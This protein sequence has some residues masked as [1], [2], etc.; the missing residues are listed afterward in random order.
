MTIGTRR[1]DEAWGTSL[2]AAIVPWL[3]TR[4]LVVGAFGAARH[5]VDELAVVPRPLQIGQGLL[6][7]DAAFYADIAGGG[8]DAVPSAGLRFFPMVPYLGRI[9]GLLPGL[10][11][12]AGVVVV[13][14]LSAL[15]FGVLFHRLVLVERGDHVLARRAV[16]IAALAPPA[17]VTVLGYAEASLML[18]A[19]A[20]FLALRSRHF[21]LAAAAGFAAGVVRPVGVL[22]ALPALIEAARGRRHLL[23][24]EVAARLLAVAAPGL[25]LLSYLLWV[26]ARTGDLLL[27]LRLHD[28]PLLRGGTV[29]PVGN[30]IEAAGDLFSGDRV[31]S[32]IHFVT[33]L[34]MVGLVVV[35]AGRW[36]ASYTAYAAVSI[37]LALTASN[38]DSL[39]RYTFATFPFLLAVADVT[40]RPAVERAVLV[41]AAGG[42]VAATVLAFTGILVP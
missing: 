37:G 16:W 29:E 7:W 24:R 2:R 34:V 5:L 32:G 40:P 8:Y 6:A 1:I 38:L 17:F 20:T 42:L 3:I 10:D 26:R 4:V 13:A 15:V 19:V 11:A 23:P 12:R 21:A 31:G 36:P 28:D 41:T 33:A 25:G 35:L 30:V 9:L 39:E 18:L 27:A 22:L 14:N